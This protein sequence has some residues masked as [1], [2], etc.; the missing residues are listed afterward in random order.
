MGT[1]TVISKDLGEEAR[2]ELKPR[3]KKQM[4]WHGMSLDRQMVDFSRTN[5][6]KS[7]GLRKKS[8]SSLK[9]MM[10]LVGGI[11]F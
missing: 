5:I 9:G 11:Y 3:G 1:E 2:L 10:A 4:P 7:G 6:P 8:G